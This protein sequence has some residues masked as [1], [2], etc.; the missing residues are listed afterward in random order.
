MKRIISFILCLSFCLCF[1]CSCGEKSVSCNNPDCTC[2]ETSGEWKPNADEPWNFTPGGYGGAVIDMAENYEY[3]YLVALVEDTFF[4]VPE[5]LEVGILN[6]TGDPA[7]HKMMFIEKYYVII[8][9]IDNPNYSTTGIYDHPNA[10][11]RIPFMTD[12]KPLETVAENRCFGRVY[13]KENL[14]AEYE[15]TPGRYRLVLP[16]YDGTTRYLEFV[17]HEEDYEEK[18][19]ELLEYYKDFLGEESIK[20]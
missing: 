17:I 4:C 1:L 6:K 9:D 12:E 10:W 15:F 11:V 20:N 5:Y 19:N 18:Y 7:A 8:Y 3:D 14:K 13:L 16:L 2:G